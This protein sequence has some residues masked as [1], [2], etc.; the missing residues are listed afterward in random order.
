MKK[1]FALILPFIL[2]LPAC[3]SKKKEPEKKF[4]SVLSLIEN[5]VAHVDT[6]LYSIIKIVQN[7]TLPADTI[8]IPREE[9]RAAAKDFLS[10]PDLSD[11]KVAKRYKEETI[12]DETINRFIISYTPE[13][14]AKEEIQKQELL[15]TPNTATGDKVTNIII[16][17][18]ISNRD[19]FMK[20]NMLWQMDRSFQVATT[21]QKP[22]KPE[23]TTTVKVVW[24]EGYDQ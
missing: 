14:P 8:Y 3:K 12:L 13:D 2:A 5:Q 22:G 20:Q 17:R 6:S 1:Y 7:D 10:I 15:V 16:D 11:K 4:I 23:K 21:L 9:F 18:V 19:S 24:N